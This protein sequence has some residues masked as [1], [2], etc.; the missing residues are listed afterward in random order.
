MVTEYRFWLVPWSIVP[1]E[2]LFISY[3]YL[4]KHCPNPMI[5]QL[6][7][8]LLRCLQYFEIKE[9][10]ALGSRRGVSLNILPNTYIAI[11]CGVFF[12]ADSILMTVQRVVQVYIVTSMEKSLITHFIKYIPSILNYIENANILLMCIFKLIQIEIYRGKVGPYKKWNFY[13]R[14]TNKSGKPIISRKT[15]ISLLTKRLFV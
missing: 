8:R 5:Q 3:T 1:L 9:K 10:I 13:Q 14:Y 7:L 12:H 6:C 2:F 4:L 15:G 11:I